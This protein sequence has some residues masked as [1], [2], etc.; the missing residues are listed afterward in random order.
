M[1]NPD[2]AKTK[3]RTAAQPLSGGVEARTVKTKIT[4]PLPGE[5]H[6]ATDTRGG[7]PEPGG[8]LHR[9]AA[10]AKKGRRRHVAIRRGRSGWAESF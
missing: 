5:S 2:E 6:S 9:H 10:R 3:T 7:D 1:K 8:S 4:G